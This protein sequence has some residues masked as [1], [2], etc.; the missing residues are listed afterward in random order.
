[1][2]RSLLAFCTTLLSFVLAVPTARSGPAPYRI[3]VSNDDGVRA[4]GLAAVAQAL[5]AIGEVIVVAPAENQSGKGHS[6]TIAEPIFRRGPHAA[7]RTAGDRADGDA[8]Q[9]VNVAHR[10]TS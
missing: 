4:P 9:H 5:Q 6:I 8:G 1:M 10:A 3:L 7:E 2:K